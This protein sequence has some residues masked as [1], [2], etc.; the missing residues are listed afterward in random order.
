MALR[1]RLDYAAIYIRPTTVRM[2]L[3][4]LRLTNILE[5]KARL[6]QP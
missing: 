3:D 4:R 5:N 2:R 1:I 6:A